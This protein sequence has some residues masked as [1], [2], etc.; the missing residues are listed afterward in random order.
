MALITV[1]GMSSRAAFVGVDDDVHVALAVQGDFA[2]T[3]ACD[4]HKAHLLDQRAESERLGGGVLNEF[5]AGDPEWIAG[6]GVVVGVD[7]AC[8]RSS[9]VSC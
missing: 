5:Y 3:M 2:R 9:A 4:R 6:C 8:I 1:V 7:H